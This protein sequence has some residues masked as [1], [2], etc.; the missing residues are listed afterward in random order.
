MNTNRQIVTVEGQA[1]K[2][3]FSDKVGSLKNGTKMPYMVIEM[4][5][6]DVKELH[7][8]KVADLEKGKEVD[9]FKSIEMTVQSEAVESAEVVETSPAAETD[10]NAVEPE[11]AVEAVSST[12]EEPIAAQNAE[13]PVSKK[14]RAIAIYKEVHAANGARKDAMKR[15][16]E[17]LHM[18]DAGA[19]TYYQNIKS[20]TWA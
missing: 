8:R 20:G 9:G 5:N 14:A 6:G 2:F 13:K 11:N 10:Q 3:S 7:P 15:F 18:S 19:N 16:K 4:L 17:E 1:V 12:V